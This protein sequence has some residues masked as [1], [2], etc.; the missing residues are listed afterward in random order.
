MGKKK[1]TLKFIIWSFNLSLDAMAQMAI[2]HGLIMF[3][4]LEKQQIMILRE[5][6]TISGFVIRQMR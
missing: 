3:L 5:L 2:W 6:I 1:K 4:I